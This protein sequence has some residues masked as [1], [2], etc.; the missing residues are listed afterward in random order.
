M[1]AIAFILESGCCM[2]LDEVKS[3]L[4]IDDSTEDE[5]ITGL[6]LA[7]EEYL[8]GAGIE[9]D[10]K[11]E[12]YKLTVKMLISNWYENRNI[13]DKKLQEVPYGLK[14]LIIQQQYKGV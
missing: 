7:S 13:T 4:R 10:Y 12:I 3:F 1:S 2:E 5:L 6:M 11:K 9:K 8:L 14:N